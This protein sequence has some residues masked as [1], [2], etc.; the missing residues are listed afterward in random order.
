M[1]RPNSEVTT[2]RLDMLQ[3]ELRRLEPELVV[4]SQPMPVYAQGEY[5]WVE[6]P[7]DPTQ[8]MK[9][10]H[11]E[12]T[13]KS[14]GPTL[15]GLLEVIDDIEEITGSEGTSMG[16]ESRSSMRFRSS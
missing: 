9:V 16:R 11:G 2:A 5:V 14:S 13:F 7:V 10:S 6:L 3:E 1:L 8:P 4:C 12:R 15:E